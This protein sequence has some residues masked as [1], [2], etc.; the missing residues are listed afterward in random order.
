[1]PFDPIEPNA[2]PLLI[3]YIVLAIFVFVN[4]VLMLMK[5]YQRKSSVAKYLAITFGLYASLAL[6][7]TLGMAQAVV[8][9]E[10]RIL[11]QVSLGFGYSMSVIASNFLL[12][13]IAELTE[14]K[15]RKLRKFYII[16]S[17]IAILLALPNNY[18]GRTVVNP[19]LPNIR[20]LTTVLMFF[21]LVGVYGYMAI[22][23]FKTAYKIDDLYG[24]RGFQFI[25]VAQICYIFTFLS[26][27]ADAIY[28][29][30]TNGDGY[31][32][33]VYF[34]N[35]FIFFWIA[36]NYLGFIYPAKMRARMERKHSQ[37]IR[38]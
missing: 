27:L 11:Y 35:G 14:M 32:I 9:G 16:S 17:V 4:A 2:K 13:F 5:W 37:E 29:T 6:M 20:M 3:L 30:V 36:F 10:K 38:A 7:L 31:T 21:Y 1:M 24:K 34:A 25:A 15:H 18:Y 22:I 19:P 12:L 33:F 28:F 8:T 23:A 26:F